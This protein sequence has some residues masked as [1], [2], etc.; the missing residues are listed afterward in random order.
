MKIIF[1]IPLISSL[2]ALNSYAQTTWADD[3]I[4]EGNMNIG[5]TTDKGNLTITGQTGNSA[6]PAIKVSGDGGVVFGGT[7]G[8]GQI[9]A[10]GSGIRFMWFPK[11][12]A[13]RFGSVYAEDANV[14]NYSLAGGN[15]VEASG[16]SS[17][18]FGFM[19]SAS[20]GES[21]AHGEGTWSGGFASVALG[22]YSGASGSASMAMGESSNASGD[23]AM[24]LGAFTQAN[25]HGAFSSGGWTTANGENS[26]AMGF[27][28]K[29]LGKYTTAMGED[30]VAASF[31]SVAV[32][33]FNS[34]EGALDEWVE[35]D[36][37]FMIGNG[38]GV[39]TDP[40]GIKNRNAFVVYKNGDARFAKRQ[41]DILMGEFG[42]PE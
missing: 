1:L 20:G 14:G 36:P 39:A 13:L 23:S 42:N 40:E 34:D 31:N 3:I 15:Y 18:A 16:D 28:T 12:A 4:V 32:G 33:R 11:R 29:A 41:G 25:G 24:A 21:F 19:S 8:T 5:T 7:F 9:P 30:T 37:L 35:T 22:L 2:F 6:L 17:V 27:L 38:T 26:T 10:V